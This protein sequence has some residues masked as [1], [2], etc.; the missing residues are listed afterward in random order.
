MLNLVW[1]VIQKCCLWTGSLQLQGTAEASSWFID[2]DEVMEN[3]SRLTKARVAEEKTAA[4]ELRKR[5]KEAERL[6][7]GVSWNFE[8]DGRIFGRVLQSFGRNSEDSCFVA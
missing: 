1:K 5:E 6:E 7:E 2:D 8:S 3:A 4:E